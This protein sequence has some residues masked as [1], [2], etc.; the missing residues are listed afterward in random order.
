MFFWMEKRA[1]SRMKMNRD[2]RKFWLLGLVVAVLAGAG[3][4]LL[5]EEQ[6]AASIEV[7]TAQ[8]FTARQDTQTALNAADNEAASAVS[9]GSRP[10]A[11]LS[12]RFHNF[13]RVGA[14]AVVR[15]E[16][17]VVNRGSAPLVIEQAYTT[18]GCT[19]A[20]ISARVIPPGKAM[21]AVVTFDAGF[22][23]SAGQTVRR[24]LI[25]ETNDPE[26]AQV[27]VWVQAS[28]K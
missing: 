3:A 18:C 13:G 12:S 21:R 28:V 9:T 1:L 14:E 6:A 22:H 4:L 26:H 24:G 10:S 15:R 19:T 7:I 25:I 23:D 8:P 27:E 5:A 2:R 17:L 11:E 20:E 16:F